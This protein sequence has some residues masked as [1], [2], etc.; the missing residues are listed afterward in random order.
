MSAAQIAVTGVG[1]ITPA[2]ADVNE[3]WHRVCEGA[4]TAAAVS[5]ELAGLPVEFCCAVPELDVGRL[6]RRNVLRLD[7]FTQLALLAAREA[8]DD[9]GLDTG[10][11]DGARVGV[12]IGC[13]I[14][15][16]GTWE[17]QHAR[18]REHG[19]STVSPL[20]IPMLIPNMVAGEIA[21]A[22]GARGPSLVTSTACASGA[23]AIAT[24]RDLLLAN[25]CDIVIAGG[26][27]APNTPLTTT[28]FANLGALSQ[29]QDPTTASRPFDVDR[30]GFVMAEAA[31]VLV[32]ERVD[33]A[34]ARGHR[35]RALLAGSG[36]TTDAHHPTSPHPEGL[37]AVRAMRAALD[38]AGLAPR[39]VEHVN[40]HGT[41]TP[42]N[43]VV[44]SRVIN[45]VLPHRPLVTSAKGVL[46]H[47]LGAAGAVEAVLTVLS[48]Q[49]SIVPPTANLDSPDPALDLNLVGKTVRQQPI[50]VALSNSFGFGGHNV[51][52]AF[53]R[54]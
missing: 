25:R 14:G 49:H 12:V 29:A 2:G 36:M 7:R 17:K 33:D 45:Q 53:C 23:T 20:F 22:H 3:T 5:P 54:P 35:P 18:L 52:L 31:G 39:D 44:E 11:W 6:G 38:D 21:L 13:G 51:V 15:G 27:E 4:S 16:V 30:D 48:V 26:T 8:V 47:S 46:G 42:L 19:A 28:G 10:T 43:D 34:A 40:A 37:G 32:L 24:A 50:G 9:A 41:A 1:M